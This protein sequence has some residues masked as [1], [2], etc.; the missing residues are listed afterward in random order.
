MSTS[1]LETYLPAE[2]FRPEPLSLTAFGLRYDNEF[3]EIQQKI[4]RK[5]YFGIP[6]SY[7]Y[8]AL[9][10]IA[11]LLDHRPYDQLSFEVEELDRIADGVAT[12][13]DLSEIS[14][15]E[16][17]FDD[18][19]KSV[20]WWRHAAEA[21]LSND[22]KY[23]DSP[24]PAFAQQREE[25]LRLLSDVLLAYVPAQQEQLIYAGDLGGP[26]SLELLKRYR[27]FGRYVCAFAQKLFPGTSHTPI[28]LSPFLERA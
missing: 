5:A 24:N 21:L 26:A 17:W 20:D 16:E 2:L 3:D 9:S 23:Y 18:I 1:V 25:I 10:A 13:D 7:S 28:D 12:E 4:R 11:W 19:L 8:D 22:R 14:C 27:L 6:M 15:D